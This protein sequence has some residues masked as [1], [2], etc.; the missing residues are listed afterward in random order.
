MDGYF[1]EQTE[2][3]VKRFQA[4]ND[5]PVTGVVDEETA[6]II[7]AKLIDKIRSGEDDRQLERALEELYK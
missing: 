4:E 7:D 5:L 3:A 1:N 2:E 6:G